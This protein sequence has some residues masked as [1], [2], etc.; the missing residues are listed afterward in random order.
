MVK[1]KKEY[2]N[3]IILDCIADG[4]FT[5]DCNQ[6]I[7]YFNRAAEKITGVKR[8]K[9]VGK[10]CYEVLRADATQCQEKCCLMESIETGK[11]KVSRKI[12]IIRSDGKQIPVTISTSVVRN[13]KGEVIGGVES[14]RDISAIELLRKKIS[15]QYS[16]YDIISKNHEIWKILNILPEIA[17]S[18]STVLIEGPSGSGKELFAKAIHDLSECSGKFV[19]LNCTAL[20]DTLLESELFGYKKGA[21]SDA[22]QDKPGRF[23][24]AEGGTLFLDEIGDISSA[25]Q[26]K[27]LRAIEKK[28]YEPL[29]STE[30]VKANVRIIAATNKKLVDLVSQNKFRDDLF[31]RLN[32]VK[33]YL[34]PLSSRREDISLLIDHFIEK[35]N[36]LK[37]KFIVDVSQEVLDC[38][39][40]YDFPGNVRELENFIEYAFILCHGS[41]IE[42]EHLPKELRNKCR[43]EESSS[44]Q[45]VEKP[46]AFSEEETIRKALAKHGWNRTATAAYLKINPSTLWRKMKKY[47]IKS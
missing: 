4:I 35:F 24:L 43:V 26:M 8:D 30:T 36:V 29:G 31:Y 2:W 18:K 15:E 9:A 1:Q 14:L 32:V 46:L 12:N 25:L 17:K 38:L 22:K 34:P 37:G 47:S 33:I 23:L 45:S 41:R 3:N 16:I 42:I 21:F 44:S 19:A 10:K 40:Q 6:N 7:T 28:E 13:E 27:L 11:D 39:M 20:P 5:I